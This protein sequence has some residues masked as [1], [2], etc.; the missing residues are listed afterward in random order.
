VFG[1]SGGTGPIPGARWQTSVTGAGLAI[2]SLSGIHR[3]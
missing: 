1:N 3:A 2:V